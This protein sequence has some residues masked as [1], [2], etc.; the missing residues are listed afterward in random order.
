LKSCRCICTLRRLPLKTAQPTGK[1]TPPERFP[2]IR[3]QLAGSIR[4]SLQP[5]NERAVISAEISCGIANAQPPARETRPT[6]VVNDQVLNLFL[7]AFRIRSRSRPASTARL[8]TTIAASGTR[9][10][11]GRNHPEGSSCRTARVNGVSVTVANGDAK[12]RIPVVETS[13]KAVLNARCS[14]CAGGVPR[15]GQERSG[16]S[17]TR[18]QNGG[19][20]RGRQLA[21]DDVAMPS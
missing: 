11:R 3:T 6:D 4:Q 14:A 20:L 16:H 8:E 13:W 9:R 17:I 19:M 15:G 21:D 1:S 18:T 5:H 2:S 7:E 10:S 12:R